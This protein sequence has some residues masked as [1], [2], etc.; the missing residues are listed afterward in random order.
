MKLKDSISKSRKSFYHHLSKLKELLIKVSEILRKTPAPVLPIPI[1]EL[2]GL[3]EA[4][5]GATNLFNDLPLE[6][7]IF[8]ALLPFAIKFIYKKLRKPPTK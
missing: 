1:D 5:L 2:C 8:I 3:W 7:R 4:V 6:Q